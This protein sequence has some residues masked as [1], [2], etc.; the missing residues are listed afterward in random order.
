MVCGKY[1][2]RRIFIEYRSC[3]IHIQPGKEDNMSVTI[4]NNLS[5]SQ[6]ALSSIAQR[7]AEL[8]ESGVKVNEAHSGELNFA[9]CASGYCQA[10]D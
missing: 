3:N 1:L 9:G 2:L 7:M 10:W 4:K 8:A 5:L 6:N